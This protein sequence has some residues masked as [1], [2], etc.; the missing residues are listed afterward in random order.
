MNHELRCVKCIM[1]ASAPG[2]SF[3]ETGTCSWC[4]SDFPGYAPRGIE[5]LKERLAGVAGRGQEADCLVAVS[6]GKDSAF[7]L[8]ALQSMFGARVEAFTYVHDGLT[9]FA[10]RNASAVCETLGV[11]HHEVRLQGQKHLELFR[12]YFSAWVDSREPVTAAMT[13]VGCK[14]LHIMGTRLAHERGIPMVVWSACPLETPPFIPTQRP[15]N[16]KA[17]SQ[18]FAG[19]GQTLARTMMRDKQFRKT[20]WASPGVNIVGCLAFRPGTSVARLL[21]C[22]VSHLHFFE[23]YPWN[24]VEMR[25]MLSS[26]T[27]WS[28]PGNQVT[29]WHSD[30]VFNVFKEYMFQSMFNVSYTDGF[31]SNQIRYG[32]LSRAQAMKDLMA[33]KEFF[34]RQFLPALET[35]GLK[36]LAPHCDTSCFGH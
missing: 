16:G 35:V 22:D 29:D 32:L 23:Y 5:A 25:R 20:F 11:R 4:R 27:P 24:A 26:R 12:A 6:G 13:C 8:L 31:L 9:D 21:Y 30:C 14:H 10:R 36:H 3:D 28:I 33:S 18:S 17:Q 2:S 1:P 34:A 7:S 19:L 15:G